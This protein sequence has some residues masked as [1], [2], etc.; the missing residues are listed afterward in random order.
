MGSSSCE[1]S[2]LPRDTEVHCI[3]CGGALFFLPDAYPL[4]FHCDQGHFQ[5]IRELLDG[6]SLQGHR[7]PAGALEYWGAKSVLLY[8]MAASALEQGHVF[9]AADF[10]ETADR[11][12]LWVSFLKEQPRTSPP[13]LPRSEPAA[14]PGELRRP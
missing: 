10:Q 13:V 12:D 8:Q 7:P 1:E 4:A 14:Q 2:H 3:S 11:I 6:S 5:T 9:L